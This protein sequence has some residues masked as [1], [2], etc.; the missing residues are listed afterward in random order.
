[1]PP[2][3]ARAGAVSA[4]VLLAA[5]AAAIARAMARGEAPDC[6]C[7][8]A[9]H[10][11]PAGAA[12]LARNL[13]LAGVAG[14]VAAAGPLESL[15]QALHGVDAG[16][17]V[18]VAALAV[19]LTT[20]G[21]FSLHLLAQNGRLI[22]RVRGLEEAVAALAPGA[23]RRPGLPIGTRAPAFVLADV[24]GE[25]RTLRELLAPGL[26]LALA[27]S[28]PGCEACSALPAALAKVRQRRAGELEVALISRGTRA[29]N[30]ARVAGH[31]LG[32]ILLQDE[33]EVA[34]QFGVAS[35]PSATIVAPDG[36]I[37]SPL[38]IGLAAIEE[39][40]A[41]VE[42][43]APAPPALRVVTG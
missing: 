14:T 29:D 16:I 21:W 33:R 23:S 13:V 37:A 7:F 40:L 5:F 28:E 36:R 11:A 22:A 30:H 4:M 1:V 42:I 34:L 8:G 12:A 43:A 15:G 20:Q 3:S 9:L 2:A 25:P 18:G 10:S 39:L 38:A 27:F 6:H 31:E 26:P 19:V 35:V 17:A 24:E 32:A 41:D